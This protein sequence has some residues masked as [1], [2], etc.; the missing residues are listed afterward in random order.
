MQRWSDAASEKGE[1]N[2]IRRSGPRTTC[3]WARRERWLS[4][5]RLCGCWDE[6]GDVGQCGSQGIEFGRRSNGITAQRGKTKVFGVVG[7]EIRDR[8]DTTIYLGNRG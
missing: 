1:D 8:D 7:G 4:G 6:R 5:C 2:H 3:R